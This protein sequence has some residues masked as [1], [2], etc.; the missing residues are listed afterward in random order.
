MTDDVDVRQV[1]RTLATPDA[2]DPSD[3]VADATA[4]TRDVRDA[5]AF[6]D[7]DGLTRLRRAIEAAE[8]RGDDAL[9]RRGRRALATLERGRDAARDH[10]RPAR[11]TV[12]S[13][14][15]LRSTR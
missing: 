12:L 15:A 10:F 1:L 3:V 8:R 4:A 11:G 7:D 6:V 14:D 5:A 13:G 2:T 9:A